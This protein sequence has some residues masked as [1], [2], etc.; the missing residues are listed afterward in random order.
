MANHVEDSL[1]DIKAI[2]NVKFYHK[3]EQEM[4]RSVEGTDEDKK[5]V[6]KIDLYFMPTIMDTVPL[7]LPDL[8]I[9]KTSRQL[10]NWASKTSS[11]PLSCL[12]CLF[13]S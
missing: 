2:E 6:R 10:P 5:L 3:K 4:E 13:L 8:A 1:K 7:L 12:A 11:T 9:S